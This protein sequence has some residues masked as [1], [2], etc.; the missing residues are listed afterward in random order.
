MEIVYSV[1]AAKQLKSIVRGDKKSAQM[2]IQGIESYSKNPSKRH[3]VKLLK[4]RF[5]LFKR[6]RIGSYRVLFDDK[7]RIMSIYE[8]KQRQGA[9]ND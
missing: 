9:Y 3:D 8:I 7:N 6:L 2:I 1:K 4:G 5:G